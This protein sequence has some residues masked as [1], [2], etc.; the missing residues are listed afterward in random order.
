VKKTARPLLLPAAAAALGLCLA[1]PAQQ[2]PQGAQGAVPPAPAPEGFAPQPDRGFVWAQLLR[3]YDEKASLLLEQGRPDAALEE[4]KKG[5]AVEV[6]KEVP[7]FELKVHLM[8]RL[9]VT[10]ADLGRKK[11]SVDAIQRL[12]AEV[13][14]GSVAEAQAWLDAGVAYRK[15]GLPDEALKALDRSIE[16]SQKLAK[17]RGPAGRPLP[18]PRGRPGRPAPQPPQGEPK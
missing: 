7:A 2:P 11:E 18:P 12:L 9:A 10:L 3:A 17:T 8:G 6:P 1:A 16:L 13:P 4:L 15:A 14:A 5:A